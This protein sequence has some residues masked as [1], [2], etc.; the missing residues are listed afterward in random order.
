M[1]ITCQKK[2]AV[3]ILG[4]TV[5]GLKAK[6]TRMATAMD[7]VQG[8]RG[9]K[10]LGMEAMVLATR[11][12]VGAVPRQAEFNTVVPLAEMTAALKKAEAEMGL[13]RRIMEWSWPS[14]G[15]GGRMY[16]AQWIRSWC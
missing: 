3:V 14:S 7:V 15:G 6:V 1:A 11:T 16:W 13:V 8:R 5:V 10:D 2:K 4:R 12:K 9:R